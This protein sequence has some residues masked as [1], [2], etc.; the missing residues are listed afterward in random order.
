MDL[1]KLKKKLEKDFGWSNLDCEDNKWFVDGLLEDATKAIEDQPNHE[2]LF[3]DEY[4]S[5]D[6]GRQCLYVDISLIRMDKYPMNPSTLALVD[7]LR[8]GGKVP[9]IK[10]AKHPKGGYVIRDGRHRILAHK[11]LGRTK[12]EARFS[13]KTMINLN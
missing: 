4:K 10:I 3:C 12:I 13:N 9:A 7:H 5:K 6:S 8:K 1:K 11:L 2:V